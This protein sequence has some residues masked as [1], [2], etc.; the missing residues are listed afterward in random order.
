[1]FEKLKRLNKSKAEEFLAENKRKDD[2]TTTASGLQYRIISEGSGVKPT[3]NDTV[4]VHYKGFLLDGTLYDSSFKRGKEQF[5][6]LVDLIPGWREVLP[7]MTEGDIYEV[8]IPPELGYGELGN[9][10]LNVPPNA[11]LHVKIELI[12]VLNK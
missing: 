7:L 4:V 1:M 5:F 12:K 3:I 6:A 9:S 11:L 10:Y 8:Y 2:I